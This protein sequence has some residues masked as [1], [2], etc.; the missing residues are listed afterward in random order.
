[1]TERETVIAVAWEWYERLLFPDDWKEEFKRLLLE[2]EDLREISF[3]NYDLV[4]NANKPGKNLIMFLYFCREL[5]KRY[6]EAGIPSEI[7]LYTIE[8]FVIS[9]QRNRILTGKIGI[10]RAEPLKNHLNM[11]LFRLG[12]LQFCMTG[13]VIDM[14]DKGIVKGDPVLDVHI[15]KGEALSE[16]G[17]VRAFREAECFFATYFPQYSYRYY[18]CFSWVLDENLRLFLKP[19]SNI[20]RFQNYFEPVYK[21][22]QDSILQFMFKYGLEDR[23]ELEYLP[24]ETEFAKRVKDYALAGGIFYNVLGVM[25]REQIKRM[26]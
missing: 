16:E 9:V 20:L 24:A 21:R 14:P 19:E 23:K 25:E 15:P 22:P 5:E 3:A 7:L 8:D 18:T 4:S 26:K 10:V 11:S 2:E 6:Q 12:R 1:V 17:C 13:A